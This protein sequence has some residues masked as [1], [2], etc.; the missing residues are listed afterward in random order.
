MFSGI[1]GLGTP[2]DYMVMNSSQEADNMIEKIDELAAAGYIFTF[3]EVL[4]HCNK[5]MSDFMPE[6]VRKMRRRVEEVTRSN[7]YTDRR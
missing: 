3:E 4:A 7:N 5:R 1:T 6:D 2:I